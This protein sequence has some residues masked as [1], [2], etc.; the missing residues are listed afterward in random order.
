[1]RE[2]TLARDVVEEI[3]S[4]GGA[5]GGWPG[6]SRFVAKAGVSSLVTERRDERSSI[7]MT[8]PFAEC[9]KRVGHPQT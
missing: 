7:P 4:T 1:M 9:A 8:H 5:P 2:T 3:R 6:L